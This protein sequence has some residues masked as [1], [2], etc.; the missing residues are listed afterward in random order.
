[1]LDCQRHGLLE[2]FALDQKDDSLLIVTL[3][4]KVHGTAL[5]YLGMGLLGKT[6][7]LGVIA[8]T[9]GDPDGMGEELTLGVVVQGLGLVVLALEVLAEF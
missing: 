1:M 5:H 2:V 8:Q 4:S 6:H 3:L 7:D 9:L